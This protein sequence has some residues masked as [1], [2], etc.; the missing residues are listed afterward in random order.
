MK[1]Q[2]KSRQKL[3]EILCPDDEC[4]FLHLREQIKLDT[5]DLFLTVTSYVCNL[6]LR[7]SFRAVQYT[8]Q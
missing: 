3:T 5:N 4:L 2:T 1:L 6:S 7:S 8:V